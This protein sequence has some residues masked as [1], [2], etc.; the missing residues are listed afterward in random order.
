MMPISN[1]NTLWDSLVKDGE[2]QGA[3]V[4]LRKLHSTGL[5]IGIESLRKR[6]LVLIELPPEPKPK[7]E[8]LPRWKGVDLQILSLSGNRSGLA[9]L[10]TDESGQSIFNSLVYD[11]DD[12]MESAGSLY[13]ALRLFREGLERWKRF[14]DKYGLDILGPK[15]QQ[16]LYGEL[17]FLH[18][19]VLSLAGTDT[20]LRSWRAHDR[21]HQDFSFVHGNVEVKTCAGREPHAVVINGEKQL[22]DAGLESLHLYCLVLDVTDSGRNTLNDLVERIRAEVKRTP[23]ALLT[24]NGYLNQAGYLDE[25]ASS[26]SGTG[27][28]I[29]KEELFKVGEGFPRI[30]DVPGGLGNLTYSLTLSAAKAFR[31]PTKESVAVIMEGRN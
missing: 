9:L 17:H 28:V 19:Y 15:Q 24:F 27:Y 7:L 31:V 2:R 8:D 10:L 13:D 29:Q 21:K 16:G 3:G 12:S 5:H 1:L 25:H 11:L 6:R 20:G 26:Y 4:L 30:V 23:G 22:D 14:F 18:E